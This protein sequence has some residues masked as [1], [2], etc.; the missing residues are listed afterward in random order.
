[1]IEQPEAGDPAR[2][3]RLTLHQELKP[4]RQTDVA[5]AR[6]LTQL[7]GSCGTRQINTSQIELT[8]SRVF[9]LDLG[10]SKQIRVRH[11]GCGIF[12][13]ANGGAIM[14][15]PRLSADFWHTREP[16]LPAQKAPAFSVSGAQAGRRPHGAYGNFVLAQDSIP[17]ADFPA[18]MGS[19]GM[20]LRKRLSQWQAQGCGDVS[21]A[22][23]FAGSPA[24]G[25]A[26]QLR[27]CHS[28]CDPARGRCTVGENRPKSRGAALG[29]AYDWCQRARCHATAAPD[30]GHPASPRPRGRTVAKVSTGA[31]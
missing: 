22:F 9:Q 14:A 13:D 12:C 7:S 19:C 20:I 15:R 1:M 2:R 6:R 8:S 18:G 23:C 11:Y 10:V 21:I 28:R 30:Q 29:Y 16:L 25:R 4:S 26:T 17:W 5:S 31:G 3:R 24:W 27:P